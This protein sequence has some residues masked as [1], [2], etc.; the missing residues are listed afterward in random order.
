[1]TNKGRWI[2]RL[3]VAFAFGAAIAGLPGCGDDAVKPSTTKTGIA[4][5]TVPAEAAKVESAIL[6]AYDAWNTKDTAKLLPYFTDRGL[7]AVI[8]NNQPGA[9]ADSVKATLADSI[10]VPKVRTNGF[11]N[12]RVTGATATTESAEVQGVVLGDARYSLVNVAGAWKVDGLE[13]LNTPVPAGATTTH[14]DLT[15]F[16]FRGDTKELGVGSGALAIEASNVGTQPHE[17]V[18]AKIPA[19]AAIDD[20]V[21]T[22]NGFEFQGEIGPVEPGKTLNIVFTEPLAA[23]RYVMVCYLPD[24]TAGGDGMSHAL[25]GMIREFTVK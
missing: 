12:T 20:L 1:M 22:G 17:L 3:A 13:W 4:A 11:K 15:E 18:I 21:K 7:V 24:T 5:P 16:A 9:T 8:T 19:D 23:G 25:K 6:A 2:T 10:G 14:V